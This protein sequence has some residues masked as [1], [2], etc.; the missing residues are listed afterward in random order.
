MKQPVAPFAHPLAR[1]L[2]SAPSNAPHSFGH[3]V[4]KAVGGLKS[5]AV[6]GQGAT[7]HVPTMLEP[8]EAVLPKET[9]A[10]LGAHNVH[11]M[12]MQTTGKAPGGLHAGGHY[13][14]GT[15][16]TVPQSSAPSSALPVT[17]NALG[18][19]GANA[20][21]SMLGRAASSLSSA[22]GSA[23]SAVGGAAG[24]LRA[25]VM[26]GTAPPAAPPVAPVPALP[27]P[28][29]P[30]AAPPAAAPPAPEAGMSL[31][32]GQALRPAATMLRGAAI[33]ALG[34]GA[35]ALASGDKNAFLD[36]P[37]TSWGD[38][39]K[40]LGRDVLTHGLSAAGAVVG[41]GAGSVVAPG[42]GTL[43][44]G[45]G[46][47]YG[48]Y[49]LGDY[50]ADQLGLG[51]PEAG[52]HAPGS[53]APQT[54]GLAPSAAPAPEAPATPQL[55]VEQRN[56]AGNEAAWNAYKASQH[57]ANQRLGASATDPNVRAGLNG[58]YRDLGNGITVGTRTGAN[59]KPQTEYTGTSPTKPQYVDAQGNPTNDYTQTAQYAQGL[60]TRASIDRTGQI[61]KD[62]A[63]EQ[64]ARDAPPR[65]SGSPTIEGM[66]AASQNRRNRA[67]DLAERGQNLQHD[68]AMNEQGV[69][70][71]GQDLTFGSNMAARQLEM[72]RL[73]NEQQNQQG[74]RNNK[75]LDQY[76]TEA[77]EKG[78]PQVNPVTR[79]RIDN[80]VGTLA[81]ERG[82]DPRS[83]SPK[84][85]QE[86]LMDDHLS[87][88]AN[89][90]NGPLVSAAK[91]IVGGNQ[92]RTIN[93]IKGLDHVSFD[94]RGGV[95]GYELGKGNWVPLNSMVGGG[96]FGTSQ[97]NGELSDYLDRI[98]ASKGGK[99]SKSYGAPQ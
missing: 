45:L 46:G 24:A 52:Y 38:R 13:M 97:Y 1:G 27:P 67:L 10:A 11:N 60:D 94:T 22:A 77:N 96:M 56:N 12:I 21:P 43:A 2:R 83:L 59:G 49:K 73:Y 78:V 71:R 98:A 4:P 92:P 79:N 54:Q 29:P 26:G 84:D 47:A 69:Q 76:S 19:S 50:A 33:P 25:R 91:T 9:V 61:Y 81:R 63:A 16:P 36:D 18:A 6:R 80:V 89:K 34:V 48:G 93:N 28:P 87:Q 75:L 65:G 37:N 51:H 8:G 30:P 35:E 58:A 74:E 85:M 88:G 53:P 17:A 14:D 82:V 70:R 55:A 20:A 57:G 86:A 72:S 44:G 66:I 64:V 62:M 15:D 31:R 99:T 41:G 5:G 3:K 39:A 40:V 68:T 23:A 7:D 90:F 95:P 32:A 42:V